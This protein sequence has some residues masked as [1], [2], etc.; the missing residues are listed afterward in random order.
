LNKYMFIDDD[1]AALL[2]RTRQMPPVIV[3]LSF[4]RVHTRVDDGLELGDVRHQYYCRFQHEDEDS[5]MKD[6][7]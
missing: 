5:T 4:R 7:G 3:P 2:K 6:E 1:G